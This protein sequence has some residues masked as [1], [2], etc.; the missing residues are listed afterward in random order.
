MSSTEVPGMSDEKLAQF[1]QLAAQ[2]AAISD[3]VAAAKVG[4]GQP[5]TDPAR[6][7][8][9]VADARVQGSRNS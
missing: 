6:E 4:T 5:V 3:R 8:V 1:V 7:A 9:V 2:R